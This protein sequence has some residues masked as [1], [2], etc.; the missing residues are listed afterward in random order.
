[1]L[2]NA[3]V[4]DGL[5]LRQLPATTAQ[6]ALPLQPL[7]TT[8][9]VIKLARLWI[10]APPS[11]AIQTLYDVIGAVQSGSLADADAAQTALAT[12]AG[13]PPVLAR[14]SPADYPKPA[15]Y[16]AVRTLERMAGTAHAT[17]AQLVG[18]GQVPA[19]ESTAE[20]I[21]SGALGVVK[22]QQA[23]NDAWLALAPT[24]M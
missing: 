14:P 21:A 11:S 22:A 8:L 4:Y 12:I 3:A 15:A 7:L 19:D 9:L 2:D 17:G 5:E 16:D 13:A 23:G 6:P 24:L 18:W 1:L 10:A 20:G